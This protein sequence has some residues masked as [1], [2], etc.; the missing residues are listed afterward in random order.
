MEANTT[1]LARLIAQDILRLQHYRASGR[2][3]PRYCDRGIERG[4]EYAE[5]RGVVGQ[6]AELLGVRD[7]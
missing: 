2:F 4:W 1:E 5:K 3:S 6:L 7:R